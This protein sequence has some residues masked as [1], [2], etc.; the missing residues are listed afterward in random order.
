MND[1]A[2]F[3]ALGKILVLLA[4]TMFVP[5]FV[6]LYYREP[7]EPFLVS[8]SVTFL[9]GLLLTQLGVELIS[10]DTASITTLGNIGP[11][12]NLF[13]P[14]ETLSLF[15][16]LVKLSLSVICGLAGWK[17]ILYWYFSQVTSGTPDPEMSSGSKTADCETIQ[18]PVFQVSLFQVSLFQVIRN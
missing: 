6:A 11:G 17:Y 4:F 12:F 3:N 16:P 18:A 1:K 2:I 9:A 5:L 14:M 8:T 15:S 10:S 7:L 13:G